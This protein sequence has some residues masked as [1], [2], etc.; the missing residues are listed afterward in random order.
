MNTYSVSEMG[1]EWDENL[2]GQRGPR[3]GILKKNQPFIN[4][5]EIGKTISEI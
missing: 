1:E 3:I 4:F 2:L 5:L